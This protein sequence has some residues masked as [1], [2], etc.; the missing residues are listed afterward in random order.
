MKIASFNI[1]N[2]RQRLRNL[3]DRRREAS[4]DVVCLQEPKATDAKFPVASIQEAGYEAIWRGQKTWNGVAL[5]SR[6]KP[7]EPL[8]DLPD[9]PNDK[10]SRY[11]EAAANGIVVASAYA[12]NGN[13]LVR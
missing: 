6:R 12:P 1:N 7:I 10:Q 4:P 11:I 8:R 9:D 13:G 3:L 2:I 5:L